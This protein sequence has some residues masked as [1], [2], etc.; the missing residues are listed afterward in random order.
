MKF[1]GNDFNLES[2][3]IGRLYPFHKKIESSLVKFN[4]KCLKRMELL[5]DKKS[6]II[7]DVDNAAFEIYNLETDEI[8]TVK[9]EKSKKPYGICIG[10]KSQLFI[11]DSASERK[12][13]VFD[14][15][16]NFLREFSIK[17]ELIVY[18]LH[19]DM[20]DNNLY[21]S[22]GDDN[23][24]TIWNSE[25]GVF[26][27]S[28]IIDSPYNMKS[29]QE[30]L[31]VLSYTQGKFDENINL[32]FDSLRR[33]ANCIFILKKPSYL[34]TNSIK[35]DDWFQ[36][37]GLYIS[38]LNIYT[39]AHKIDENRIISGNRFLFVINK[40]GEVEDKIELMGTPFGTAFNSS[41]IFDKKLFFSF[42]KAIGIFDYQKCIG[43][44]VLN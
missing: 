39:T 5:P 30:N 14:T 22:H 34:V 1:V 41:A 29:N 17:K 11:T 27:K 38:G 43:F 4:S 37:D 21:V 19:F 2:D 3:I 15:S 12:V 9:H 24:I 25:T 23:Q 8:K 31:F 13:Q 10:E 33:G 44:S 26:N 6:I 7:S 35:F 42:N 40:N 32:K 28:L 18:D 16:L 36:P 20:F